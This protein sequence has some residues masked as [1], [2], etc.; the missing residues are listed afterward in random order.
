[1]NTGEKDGRGWGENMTQIQVSGNNT[2]IVNFETRKVIKNDVVHEIPKHLKCRNVSTI[3][4]EVYVDGY[5]LMDDGSWK[6]TVK[7]WWES[8]KK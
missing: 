1:M 6:R 2:T 4:G 7:S 3:N 8:I 5:Q